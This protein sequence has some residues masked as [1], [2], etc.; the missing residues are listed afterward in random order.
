MDEHEDGPR[1]QGLADAKGTTVRNLIERSASFY[2]QLPAAARH[3]LRVVAALADEKICTGCKRVMA[4]IASEFGGVPSSVASCRRGVDG[5][6][7]RVGHYPG[8]MPN[9]EELS[10]I[11]PLSLESIGATLR[12]VQADQRLLRSEVESVRREIRGLNESMASI[13]AR[14]DTRF[15]QMQPEVVR[16][17]DKAT[18]SQLV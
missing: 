6:S 17:M 2:A 8:L 4:R 18:S 12:T 14:I 16:L 9:K 1:L 7:T 13:E 15:D 11:D 3:T 5:Y 10:M